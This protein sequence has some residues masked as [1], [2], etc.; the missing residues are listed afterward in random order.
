[1]Y[2][3][4]P[5]KEDDHLLQR[6]EKQ[7]L[8][9]S[10]R[11]LSGDPYPSHIREANGGDDCC[12]LNSSD[13]Q[14]KQSSRLKFCFG[15]FTF[16]AILLPLLFLV[17]IPEVT[18]GMVD[19]SDLVIIEANIINPND[20]SF[21][22]HVTQ[23]FKG[24]E[25]TH[26][27]IQMHKLSLQWNDGTG[28]KKLAALT[29]SNE[30][31]ITTSKVTLKSQA[32]VKDIDALSEF[33]LFAISADKFKW[34]IHGTATVETSGL[35]IPVD[36]DKTVDMVGF[37][38]FP[39]PPVIDQINIT[40]GTPTII[41][42]EI[43]ATFTNDANIAIS[44]GQD[45][46]FT[47]KSEEITIGTGVIPDLDLKTGVF[48]VS[49]FV[50]LTATPETTEYDQLMK[51]ISNFTTGLPSPVTMGP[52][53]AT[54]TIQWLEAGL[55][56]MNLLSAIPGLTEKLI[57]SV[58]MYP[59]GTLVIPFEM[60]MKNPIDTIFR[61]TH[62]KATIYSSGIA[63]STVDA[64]VDITIP[65]RSS[66]ISPLINANAIYTTEALTE[67]GRLEIVGS[68]LLNVRSTLTGAINEFPTLS[69]YAQDNVPATIHHQA[70]LEH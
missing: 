67:L 31:D 42:N 41:T 62:L 57:T 6:N 12:G 5:V 10:E 39:I 18:Q 33:N 13:S 49:A 30:V 19:D 34:Q 52:F 61:L 47:L 29:H 36:V 64:D 21:Q 55:A 68:G 46:E 69:T 16:L 15:C 1:M 58:D 24:V 53:K 8:S 23:K 66:I 32:T 44:F 3:S 60:N 65:P 26:G 35:T 25:G 70:R 22:S 11:Q 28:N 51:V 50:Y 14:I 27:T 4:L 45:V 63:I 40:N 56:S 38:N 2:D 17:I 7:S 54:T 59:N 48:P 37:N 43:L 9:V 20:V